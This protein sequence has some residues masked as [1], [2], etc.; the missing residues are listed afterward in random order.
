MRVGLRPEHAGHQKLRLGIAVREHANERN[1]AAG[2]HRQARLPEVAL[3]GELER[4]GKPR[5]QW[6]RVPAAE[7]GMDVKVHAGAVGRIALQ[8]RLDRSAGLFG[9]QGGR[10]A[11]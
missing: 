10:L 5:R 2:T 8:Y 4:V 6:W 7:R 3:R 1:A 11:Q 9:V